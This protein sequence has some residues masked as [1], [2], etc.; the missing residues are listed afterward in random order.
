MRISKKNNDSFI[1][2]YFVMFFVVLAFID[3]FFV[4]IAFDSFKGVT[5]KNSY[6]KGLE[7][8]KTIIASEKQELLN[9]ESEITIKDGVMIFYLKDKYNKSV[10]N[11]KVNAYLKLVSQAGH[12]FKLYLDYD[13]SIKAYK[14]IIIFPVKGQWD[15]RVLFQL[16]EINFQKTKRVLVK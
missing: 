13:S 1:P 6:E 2:Y 16:N 12:D 7:Y 4:F 15:I 10:I 5:V 11:G 9:W 8:N 3:F 14:N